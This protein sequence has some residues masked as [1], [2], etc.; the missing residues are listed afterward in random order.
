MS[1]VNRQQFLSIWY[2]ECMERG[3]LVLDKLTNHEYIIDDPEEQKDS[4]PSSDTIIIS[5]EERIDM[6]KYF[7]GKYEYFDRSVMCDYLFMTELLTILHPKE[8]SFVTLYEAIGEGVEFENGHADIMKE[9]LLHIKKF[10]KRRNLKP[11]PGYLKDILKTY[12]QESSYF[13]VLEIIF[14]ISFM[15][16]DVYSLLDYPKEFFTSSLS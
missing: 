13:I 11:K 12:D 1:L 14:T 6:F 4:S 10:F 15:C 8:F 9:L 2:K 7:M 16:K 5:V 3:A